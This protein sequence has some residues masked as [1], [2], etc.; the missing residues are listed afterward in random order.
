MK[1]SWIILTYNR[2]KLSED[3]FLKNIDSLQEGNSIKLERICVDNGSCEDLGYDDDGHE[4]GLLMWRFSNINVFN[5]KNLGVAK[6]YNQ[7]LSMAT[8]D[9]IVI[10]GCDRVMPKHWLSIWIHHFEKIPNTGIISCYSVPMDS[11][12]ERKRDPKKEIE[13]NGMKIIPAMPMEAKIFSRDLHRKIGYLR[14][15][16]GLYGWEDVEWGHRAE[17]VTKELGL[18]NYIIPGMQAEHLGSEGIKEW[19]GIDDKEYHEFKQKESSDPK[20]KELMDRCW[21]ENFKYYNPYI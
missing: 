13:V 5:S 6:G 1:V 15:D 7:G 3:V 21:K 11:V 9:Y 19:N 16:F 20:K 4:V 2:L 10:T 8:G 12:P 14:E 18:I 17:R